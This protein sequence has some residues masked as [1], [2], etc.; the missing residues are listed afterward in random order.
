MYQSIEDIKLET[1][2]FDWI[3]KTTNINHLKRAIRL[4]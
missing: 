3:K 2:D 1:I 4:I